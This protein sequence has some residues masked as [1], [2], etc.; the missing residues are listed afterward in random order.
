MNRTRTAL[1]SLVLSP[2]AAFA[3]APAAPANPGY[4][5][6]PIVDNIDLKDGDTLVFLGDSI[7]HQC[8]YTQYVEDFYYTRY[9]KLRLHFHNS[10]VGGD[11]ASDALRRFDEDVAAYKPK[12]VTI[13]LGMNDGTY[14]NYQ[15]AVFDTYQKDMTTVLDRIKEIGAVAVPM[16]PTMF[17]SRAK[18]MFAAPQ[19]QNPVREKYYSGVLALF[20]AWLREEAYDRGLGFVDMNSP[21]NAISLEQRTKDPAWTMIRDGVHP[22]QTGQ[23]VMACSILWDMVPRSTVSQTTIAE[24]NGKVGIFAANAKATELSAQ[25]DKVSFTLEANALPWVL[26]EDAAE[27][28]KLAAAGHRYSNEKLTV[29]TLKPGRYEVK[30]DGQAVGAWSAEELSR[31]VELETN[32]KTPQYQ[33]ALQVAMLNK[34]RNDEA[35]HPLRDQYGQLKGQRRAL[36]QAEDAKAP[37]FAAKKA[38]FE[39]WYSGQKAK[40]AELLAKAKTI[41]DEIY[42]ANQPKPHRYEIASAPAP[43]AAKTAAKK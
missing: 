33:Q 6:K 20:G 39:T 26:P 42:K 8:L 24:R 36:K 9:P 7:T 4:T 12:Y 19:A 15:Q 30:I 21:L 17:D 10:G 2:L 27:G 25:P 29:Q 28:F 37:D 5:P 13:L 11:R 43:A 14:T 18:K 3:Q 31:G 38:A 22:G 16:T 32:A 35:Y 41:E 34:K 40:V 1:L 23:V